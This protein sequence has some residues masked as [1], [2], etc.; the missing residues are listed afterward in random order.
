MK[1]DRL[2]GI[3]TVLLQNDSVTA[4]QLAERFEV[5]RRTISRDIEALCQAG[6]PVVTRQGGGGGISIAEGFKIDKSV[7]TREELS[8]IIAALKGLGSVTEGGRTERMMEK[9]FAQG[10]AVVSLRE[11]VIIDLASQHKNS[12]TRQIHLV[13]QAVRESRKIAFTYCYEKG[14]CRR[15]IEPSYVIFHWAAWYVFGYCELRQ[16]FRLFKLSRLWDLRVLDDTFVPREVPA[17]R[18]DLDGRFPD[19]TR[20]MALCDPA[21][22][23]QLIDTYGQDCYREREDGQLLLEVGYTNQDFMMTWLLGLGG[24]VQVLEPPELREAMR[25]EAEKILRQYV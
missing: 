13:K 1:I 5:S 7:L 16:D 24:R 11:S 9:L 2:M 8:E 25:A 22:R 17:H 15:C 10:D 3:L 14:E 20:L 19:D 12:Q 4:P 21:I 18:R 6:I 23:Y